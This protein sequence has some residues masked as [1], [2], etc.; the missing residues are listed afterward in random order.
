MHCA[1]LLFSVFAIAIAVPIVQDTNVEQTLA[2]IKYEYA[3]DISAPI[4]TT[5]VACLKKSNYTT[6]Y[7][8]GYSDDKGGTFDSNVCDNWHNTN[9][10]GLKTTI[11]MT[12]NARSVKNGSQQFDEFYY[13]LL[14]SCHIK[15]KTVWIEVPSSSKWPVDSSK[16]LGFLNDII[17]TARKRAVTTMGIFTNQAEWDHITRGEKELTKGL[18]LWYWKS[19]AG[20]QTPPNFDDFRAFGSWTAPDVKRFATKVSQC[21]ISVNSMLAIAVPQSNPHP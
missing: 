4:T 20:S 8:R 10:G 5:A 15:L 16:S 19:P 14:N 1:L 11:Y 18:K 6:A 13:G 7:I 21:G 2:T 17:T 12:P 3:F 9:N